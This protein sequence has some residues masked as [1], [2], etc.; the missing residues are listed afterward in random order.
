MRLLLLFSLAQLWAAPSAGVEVHAAS[1]TQVIFPLINFLIFLYLV[2]RFLFPFI[3]DHL[4][5]RRE[6][7]LRSVKEADEGRERAEAMVRDYRDRLARLDEETKKIRETLHAEGEREK[8]KLLAEAEELATKIRADA[9]FLAQQELKVAQ[10]RMREEIARIAQTAAE[11]AVQRHLTSADQRRLVEG[12]LQ[13]VGR[14]GEVGQ[15]G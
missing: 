4:R 6:E 2:K 15:G 13:E 9:D 10:Q 1:V 12:F 5:S 3:K 8:I 14:V 11:Q 7:I